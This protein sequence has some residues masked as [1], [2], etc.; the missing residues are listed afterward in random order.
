MRN[1]IHFVPVFTSI[2]AFIFAGILYQRWRSKPA[3]L[4]LAWWT[5][6]VVTYGVGTLTE[7]M[8]TLFGWHLWIFRAWYISGALLGGMPLA[9]GTVYLVLSKK[10]ANWLTI[11]LVAYIAVASVFILLSP[12]NQALVE[13]DRLSGSVLVW[14]WARL[15]SPFINLYALIFLVGGAILSAWKYWRRDNELGTRVLGNI[16]IA[17]GALLPGIGGSFT[18]FGLVEVLYVTEIL[19]LALIWLG[20][21]LMVADSAVSIHLAQRRNAN[22]AV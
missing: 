11:I 3:S 15:F 13:P 5:I 6:G 8:T 7:S 9:Q 17:L 1:L 12:I 20:Y 19:G 22:Q 14:Q 18:R 4:Y 16:C 10:V 21:Q 2:I